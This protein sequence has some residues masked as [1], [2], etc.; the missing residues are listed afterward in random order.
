[1]D[2]LNSSVPCHLLQL[3]GNNPD[4]QTSFAIVSSNKKDICCTYK[5]YLGKDG[6]PFAFINK[7][8]VP[9]HRFI[10]YLNN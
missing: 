4:S 10:W 8:R 3:Y 2:S 6:Y 5:W 7:S 1:M 9:L